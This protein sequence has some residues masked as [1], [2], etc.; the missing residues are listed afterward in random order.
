MYAIQRSG[1]NDRTYNIWNR[2]WSKIKMRNKY[3]RKKVNGKN[4]QLHRFIMEQH[5]GRE[6][7]IDEVVHHIDGDIFNN[8]ISNLKVMTNSEHMRMHNK[9]RIISDKTRKLMSESRKKWNET[10]DQ[11]MLGKKHTKETK[12]KMSESQSGSKGNMYGKIGSKN[13]NWIEGKVCYN[14]IAGRRHR[15]WKRIMEGR[16]KLYDFMLMKETGGFI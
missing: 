2:N 4:M 3:K 8:D 10:H 1:L 16:G 15:A 7:D 11:P 5:L 9:G 14:T 6:L 12:R 13:H